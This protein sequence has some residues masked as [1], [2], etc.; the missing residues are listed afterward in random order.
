MDTHIGAE[1]IHTGYGRDQ[2]D[3]FAALPD[4]RIS[5]I[6]SDVQSQ[7]TQGDLYGGILWP[8]VIDPY[9]RGQELEMKIG[10]KAV[11]V[12]NCRSVTTV[13]QFRK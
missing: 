5:T 9:N 3:G 11:D 1:A 13:T 8:D 2:A 7:S 4:T 6:S 10:G 12:F